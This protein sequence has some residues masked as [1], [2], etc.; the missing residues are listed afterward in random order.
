[1][2]PAYICNSVTVY[3]SSSDQVDESY[4][5]AAREL[6]KCLAQNGY[7]LVFGGGR[8]GLMGALSTAAQNHGGRVVGVILKEFHDLGVSDPGVSEMEVY[9]DMRSRKAGLERA[10]DAYVALPGGLGTFEEITEILSFKQLGFHNKPIV[11]VNT[12]GYFDHLLKQ[13]EKCFDEKF[14]E[15]RFRNLF[16]VVDSALEAIE[17]IKNYRPTQQNL[18]YNWHLKS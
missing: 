11:F 3:C 9:K 12:N 17:I 2:G 7:T 1:M 8:I 6:G 18:K 16:S 4:T 14:I 10:G 13:F 5:I 15:P